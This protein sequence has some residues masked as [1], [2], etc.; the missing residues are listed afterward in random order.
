MKKFKY[1]KNFDNLLLE[2]LN[3]SEQNIFILTEEQLNTLIDKLE[4]DISSNTDEDLN[5]V[6]SKSI[7]TNLNKNKFNSISLIKKIEDA[8]KSTLVVTNRVSIY[9]SV[10]KILNIFKIK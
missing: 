9:R 6:I 5:S 3:I 8:I 7:K 10:E 2:N 4:K 1:I